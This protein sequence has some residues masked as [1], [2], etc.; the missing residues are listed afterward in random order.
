MI[1]EMKMIK[2]I[3]LVI[4]LLVAAAFAYAAPQASNVI[5]TNTLPV[6]TNDNIIC[7]FNLNSTGG[8]A[9]WANVTW[10]RNSAVQSVVQKGPVTSA[11]ALTDVMLNSQTTKGESWSCSVTAFN[12][13]E[14]AAAIV[15]NTVNIAN[16]N[17][18]LNDIP[19]QTYVR[20]Y[21]SGSVSLST[22]AVDPDADTITFSASN[23]DTNI[24]CGISGQSLTYTPISGFTG[25]GYCDVTAY[26]GTYLTA[27][28][29]VTITVR[30]QI[31][32]LSVPSEVYLG[33]SS[34]QDR[35][36]S[37]SGSFVISNAGTT[38]DRSVTGIEIYSNAASQY[39]VNFSLDNSNFYQTISGFS[40]TPG[41]SRTIYYK[42]YVPEDMESGTT[43][44]GDIT[45]RANEINKTISNFY[46][47]TDQMLT[48]YDIIADVDGE[49]D[50]SISNSGDDISEKAKPGSV[51]EIQIKLENQFSDS[52]DID[53]ED[54]QITGTLYDI[55]ADHDDLDEETSTFD[56]SADSKSD[57][58]TLTFNIPSDAE[59]GSYDI[60]ITAEGTD[61]EYDTEHS[62]SVT[63]TLDVEREKHEISISRAVLSSSTINCG[64]YTTLDVIIKNT[65]SNDEDETVLTVKNP[66]LGLTYT[67]ENLELDKDPDNDDNEFSKTFTIDLRN[68]ELTPGTYPIEI[69]TFYSEDV[70]SDLKTVYL[71]V[72]CG[73]TVVVETKDN[74]VVL[75]DE[76]YDLV[77]KG[78]GAIAEDSTN[79]TEKSFFKSKTY[80]ALLILANLI[81][82][83][84]AIALVSK[85]LMARK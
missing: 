37:V 81:V 9:V 71:T 31:T 48:I 3:L 60:E 17:V 72:K 84:V 10:Y 19:A 33:S 82:V 16:T 13:S 78:Q 69:Q 24:A 21:S 43:D 1:G 14:S 6:V 70:L 62:V 80:F 53:I 11:Q 55:G 51:V 38:G 56:I 64:D 18:V 85:F 5:I 54:I 46:V 57:Y 7:S 29:R 30:D 27:A 73:G 68:K 41:N 49:S 15:S 76:A 45:V 65:G 22:Y 28:K 77:T 26:D 12:M 61:S 50:S 34:G 32:D 35:D 8:E 44:I 83:I 79:T 36:S 40:L 63:L 4:V 75:T 20:G 58:K 42:G 67:S 39:K 23:V 2:Q 25:T 59:E 47:K 74:T 52:S 66:N